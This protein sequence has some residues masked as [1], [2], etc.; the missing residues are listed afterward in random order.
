MMDE[1]VLSW[2]SILIR[3]NIQKVEIVQELILSLH[4]IEEC[5]WYDYMEHLMFI[6]DSKF[7]C[8]ETYERDFSSCTLVI[9]DKRFYQ[10]ESF[11][12]FDF[13]NRQWGK[14]NKYFKVYD[15]PNG[16]SH[17]CCTSQGYILIRY[18]ERFFTSEDYVMAMLDLLIILESIGGAR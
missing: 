4:Y 17:Y 11:K 8:I 15:Y 7:E 6:L 9:R 12:S 2:N 18:D 3:A 10:S 16:F 14:L 5:D 1:Y 13:K